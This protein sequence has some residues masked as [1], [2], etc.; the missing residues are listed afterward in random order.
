[1]TPSIAPPSTPRGFVC[2]YGRIQPDSSTTFLQPREGSS[3]TQLPSASI[4]AHSDLQPREGSSVTCSSVPSWPPPFSL[5][6]REGSS[7]TKSSQPV[8][9]IAMSLQPREGSSVT[10]NRLYLQL[11]WR[12]LQPREGSSVTMW[13]SGVSGV[14]LPGFEA[15]FPSTRNTPQTPRGRRKREATD[16]D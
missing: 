12:V 10:T 14:K 8:V 6:P 4:P 2:N 16:R 5:Q 11:K 15:A 1:M 7:V 13:Y 9:S 3:V